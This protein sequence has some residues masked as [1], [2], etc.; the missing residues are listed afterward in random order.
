M[1]ENYKVYVCL[2]IIAVVKWSV[3]VKR[4]KARNGFLRAD[5]IY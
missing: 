2:A 5:V 3:G 1:A 4:F